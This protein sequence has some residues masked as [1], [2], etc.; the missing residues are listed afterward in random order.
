MSKLLLNLRH[1]GNDEYHDVCTLLDQHRIAWYRTEPSP[2]GISNGGLWIRD[3]DDLARARD[4]M[5][6]YQ[7]ERSVRMRAEREQA[8]Q[9]GSA[10]TF[11][12]LLQR[13][14]GFVALVL[15]G[16]VGA[17]ALV[18]LPFMLLRG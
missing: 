6:A 8:L 3:D 11:S 13:R 5:G 15:L 18:L 1:V 16:M 17:A 12:G 14:P 10:E 2:W 7:R 9:D 4:V